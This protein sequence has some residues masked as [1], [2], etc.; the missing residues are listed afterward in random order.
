MNMISNLNLQSMVSA[1]GGQPMTT[2]YA[3]AEAFGKRHSDVLRAIKNIDCSPEFASTHFC[4]QAKTV[5]ISNGATRKVQHYKMTKDGFMFLVMGFT[6]KLAAQTKE[7]FIN[8]FN[9]MASQLHQVLKSDFA[10]Y[11]QVSLKREHRKQHV[12][13]SARD[14]RVWQDEKPILDAELLR[15]EAKLQPSLDFDKVG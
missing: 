3:V 8:A 14:M 10:R 7:S 13:C 5:N 15:L 4:V 12:S 2:S 1:D 6:G 9:W 11:N